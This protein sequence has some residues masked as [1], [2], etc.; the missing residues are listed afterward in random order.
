VDNG[1]SITYSA[2]GLPSWATI[3][4]TTGVISGTPSSAAGAQTV[5]ITGTDSAG[6][7]VTTTFTLGAAN[8]SAPAATADTASATEAGGTNNGTAGVDPGGNVTSNDTGNGIHV[9]SA[10][11]GSTIDGSA[12]TVAASSTSTSNATNIT[13]TY[14]TLH[15]GADGSYTY[16]VNNGNATVQALNPSQSLS[17]TFSYQITDQGAQ[18]A[19]ATLTITIHGANDAPTVP[20]APSNQS[21]T[22]GSA[23]SYTIPAFADVD[24]GDSITYSASGLPSWATI[25]PTTGVISGTPSSAAG[26]QTVTITGTDSAGTTVS[27]S[28]TVGINPAPYVPPV[29]APSTVLPPAVIPV[30]STPSVPTLE[31]PTVTP[32]V[33]TLVVAN[34]VKD[35]LVNNTSPAQA[36]AADIGM[37]NRDGNTGDADLLTQ[38]AAGALRIPVIKSSEPALLVFHGVPDQNFDTGQSVRFQLPPDVFVHTQEN[39]VVSVTAQRA[40]GGPLP[41]WLKF[42]PTTGKFEGLAPA[43][44]ANELAVLLIARDSVGREVT[45][46]FRIKLV[47]K[48]QQHVI[49]RSGLSDQLRQAAQRMPQLDR[50][51]RAERVAKAQRDHITA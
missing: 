18:T 19:T 2:S 30:F 13:G 3:N 6:A 11:A 21:A 42:D 46:I 45:T 17:E 22:V 48:G 12:S 29:Q 41:T 32:P 31:K 39:A 7:T 37:G 8:P 47:T 34:P 14:G 40:D 25:N 23:F 26:A 50:A 10:E 51:A 27:T 28:F 36:L 9:S 35:P 16:S 44:S 15:I 38:P 5:T 20:T 24:N 4:P 43:G 1:D 33:N 49:G